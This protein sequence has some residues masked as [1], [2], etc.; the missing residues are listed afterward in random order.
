[1]Q[2]IE[3][4]VASTCG[5][6]ALKDLRGACMIDGGDGSD[7][8]GVLHGEVAEVKGWPEELG[9][10]RELGIQGGWKDGE[11]VVGH[12]EPVGMCERRG[13]GELK[14][15]GGTMNYVGVVVEEK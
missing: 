9:K 13:F 8:G 10:L 15:L 1:M 14:F 7:G 12:G 6:A 4:K 5:G 2:K 11:R 3:R